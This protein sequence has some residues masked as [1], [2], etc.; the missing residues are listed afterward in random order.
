VGT[1][2][3]VQVSRVDLDGRKIDFR[4][5]R[6]G[7]SEKLLDKGRS[8][9]T[10]G[11]SAVAELGNVR[12]ADRQTKAASRAIKTGVAADA[13]KRSRKP[14]ARRPTPRARARR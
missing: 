14:A 8:E 13:G 3:R 12:E 4:M 1:R 6:E 10:K 11:S 7:E 5:V 9:R 2:V